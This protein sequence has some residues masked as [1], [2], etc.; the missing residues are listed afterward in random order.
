MESSYLQ[1]KETFKTELLNGLYGTKDV[2]SSINPL[3]TFIECLPSGRESGIYLVVDLG[4]TNLRVGTVCLN[5][6]PPAP[7][8]LKI[9]ELIKSNNHVFLKESRCYWLLKQSWQVPLHISTDPKGGAAL[10]SFIADCILIYLETF[11]VQNLLFSDEIRLGFTF[12][13]PVNQ[14]HLA[15]GIIK[16]FAK[17]FQCGDCIG[18]DA[19]ILLEKALEKKSFDNIKVHAL[20]NDTVG[21][22]LTNLFMSRGSQIKVGLI[23][24]TGT[25]AAIVLDSKSKCFV[26]SDGSLNIERNL[27]ITQKIPTIVNLEWG[28]FHLDSRHR[29]IYDDQLDRESSNPGSQF[30]EKMISGKYLGELVRLQIHAHTSMVHCPASQPYCLRSEDLAYLESMSITEENLV[31]KFLAQKLSI[32]LNAITIDD[33]TVLSFCKKI[34]QRSADLVACALTA[35][36]E[37]FGDGPSFGISVDGSM[38]HH[39][40]GYQDGI[41]RRINELN[42]S[43]MIFFETGEDFSI[44][45][46]AVAAALSKP[47]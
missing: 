31:K 14:I 23:L 38:Y 40:C 45:G 42:P 18:K 21:V 36:Y 39:Y 32:P 22:L 33:F 20:I 27:K 15:H 7:L 29:T 46:A 9:K 26:N 37:I 35:I 28:S 1:I 44:V 47:S 11:N 4:G 25:N 30:F 16:S 34:S 13:Y 3:P 24:G 8:L 6:L 2:V 17:G 12:S 5:C 19:A 10:F 41:K 43:N